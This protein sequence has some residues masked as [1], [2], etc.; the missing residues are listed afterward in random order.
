MKTDRFSRL[1]VAFMGLLGLSMAE[2]AVAQT[3]TFD[4]R[5]ASGDIEQMI[6]ADSELGALDRTLSVVYAA[7]RRKAANERPPT[8]QA[9]QRGWV[10]GRNDCWKAQDRRQCVADAYRLRIAE[11]Q[12]RYRLIPVSASATFVC[13]GD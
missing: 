7:A 2:L 1:T 9:E 11:L 6:C 12:A 10:K 5:K 8:L 3:P 4:C 13:D